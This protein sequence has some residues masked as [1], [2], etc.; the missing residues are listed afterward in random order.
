MSDTGIG[1][2]LVDSTT[3]PLIASCMDW[4]KHFYRDPPF[5]AELPHFE[6]V[7]SPRLACT[8]EQD[9]P[10]TGYVVDTLT[11]ALWCLLTSADYRVRGNHGPFVPR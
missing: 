3:I 5:A 11:A 2:D 9:I 1:K 6:Q 4:A 10:S 7:F 8:A